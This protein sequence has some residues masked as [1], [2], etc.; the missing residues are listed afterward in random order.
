MGDIKLKKMVPTD[1]CQ[2]TMVVSGLGSHRIDYFGS[3]RI[4]IDNTGDEASL[5]YP[6]HCCTGKM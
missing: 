4:R 6:H 2:F 1:L 3:D 5:W